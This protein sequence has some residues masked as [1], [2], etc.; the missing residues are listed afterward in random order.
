MLVKKSTHFELDQLCLNLNAIL[1]FE[2]NTL[3][4][5]SCAGVSAAHVMLRFLTSGQKH[6]CFRQ[7]VWACSG[8]RVLGSCMTCV[9]T[10]YI[11]F[12]ENVS[13]L[14]QLNKVS[15]PATSLEVWGQPS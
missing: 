8:V 15:Y 10:L 9:A 7:V 6:G 14:G 5:G 2:L 13:A 1:L 12:C 3:A 4:D 11:F